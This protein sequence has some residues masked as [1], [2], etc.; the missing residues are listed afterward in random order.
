LEHFES[1]SPLVTQVACEVDGGHATAPQLALED[2]AAS[3]GIGERRV[4]CGHGNAG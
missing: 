1:D 3:Q 4:D 2:V